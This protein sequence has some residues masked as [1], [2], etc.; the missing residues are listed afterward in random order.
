MRPQAPCG[1]PQR[2]GHGIEAVLKDADFSDTTLWYPDGEV[3]VC[4]PAGHGSG[5]LDWL[6]DCPRQ[7]ARE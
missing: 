4:E 1:S 6:D 5:L 7:I 3:A 2:P